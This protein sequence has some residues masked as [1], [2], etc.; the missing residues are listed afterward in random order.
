MPF[1]SS[2]N[3]NI[4]IQKISNNIAGEWLTIIT[5]KNEAKVDTVGVVKQSGA[6]ADVI[7]QDAADLPTALIL[8]NELKAQFNL[9]LTSDR[10]SGQQA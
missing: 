3:E 10:E 4:Y 2:G 9:K 8:V 5:S 7:S 1:R 6:V